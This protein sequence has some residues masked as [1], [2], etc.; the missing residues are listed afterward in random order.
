MLSFLIGLAAL[1]LALIALNAFKGANVQVI[2][3]QLRA[4]VG[5]AVL[6][7]A[8]V[9]GIRGQLSYALP[10]ATAGLWLLF[11]GA[12]AP[13][14]TLPGGGQ[15]TGGQSS[16]IV[17]DHLEMELDHDSGAMR[18]RVLKGVFAGRA[19]ERLAPAELALL[20]RDCRYSDPRSAQLIEAYLDRTHPTWREDM[21]RAE[22]ESGYGGI[23]SREQAYEI[24]GLKPGASEEE[25]RRA[26]REL[27]KKMHPDRGGSDYLASK[28]N[29][30]K[31]VLLGR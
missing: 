5:I 26:H 3:R 1:I 2:A 11:G 15:P 10:L 22:N 14:A 24:L 23:V 29:E 12:G 7:G 9:L 30:A 28:I 25:I 8:A 17:T 18:G 16:R 27:M 19:I 4:I 21:S 31:D 20:W 6:A 13:W